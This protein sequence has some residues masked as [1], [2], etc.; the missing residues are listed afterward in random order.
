MVQAMHHTDRQHFDK[1]RFDKQR[2]VGSFN[3]NM[4]EYKSDILR[5]PTA[6]GTIETPK[7]SMP[8]FGIRI[9]S[10]RA[11][12]LARIHTYTGRADIVRRHAIALD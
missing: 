6:Q 9:D 4:S 8:T 11:A 7:R 3:S 10:E 1:R 2:F 5:K 12:A